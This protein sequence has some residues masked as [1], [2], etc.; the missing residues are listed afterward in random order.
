MK[1]LRRSGGN[2]VSKTHLG[3][4]ELTD[5]TENRVVYDVHRL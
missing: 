1:G 5:F 3:Q 2:I 4:S